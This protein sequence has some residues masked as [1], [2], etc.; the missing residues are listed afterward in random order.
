MSLYFF[1]P[2]YSINSYRHRKSNCKCLNPSLFSN[3]YYLDDVRGFLLYIVAMPKNAQEKN[4]KSFTQ[5]LLVQVTGC[6]F[7]RLLSSVN[8]GKDRVLPPPQKM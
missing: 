5:Q 3:T 1:V 2:N 7:S 4:E 6:S 8:G